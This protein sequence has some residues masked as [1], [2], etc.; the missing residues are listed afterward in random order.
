MKHAKVYDTKTKNNKLS[1]SA[2][3]HSFLGIQNNKTLPNPSVV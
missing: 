2:I 1:K 3:L